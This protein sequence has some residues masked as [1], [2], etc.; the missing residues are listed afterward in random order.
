MELYA[1]LVALIGE[2][3][4][5]VA[6]ERCGI[7]DIVVAL[8]SVPHRES[9][10]VA[11]GECDVFRAGIL[12]RF[13]PFGGVEIG[14]IESFGSLGILVGC[15]IVIVEI[16]LSLGEHAVYAPVDE[17]AESVVGEFLLCLLSFGSRDIGRCVLVG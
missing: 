15:D 1:L 7:D 3:A 11:C 16:P 14:G 6:L 8:V 9:V 13:H 2:L 4:Q 5:D 10:V 17:Y 12:Y